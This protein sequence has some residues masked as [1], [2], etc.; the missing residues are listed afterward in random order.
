MRQSCLSPQS[1][2]ADEV[3]AECNQGEGYR[4]LQKYMKTSVSDETSACHARPRAYCCTLQREAEQLSWHLKR[5][6][7]GYSASHCGSA[8]FL[9]DDRCCLGSLTTD[10]WHLHQ[11]LVR[12]HRLGLCQPVSTQVQ[13]H[14]MLHGL[15][16]CSC[17][18]QDR[19]FTCKS[20]L[21]VMTLEMHQEQL[22]LPGLHSINCIL[23]RGSW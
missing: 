14:L 16:V 9:Q 12:V 19:H 21:L 1:S 13:L 2:R 7:R 8:G 18:V 17:F 4:M 6:V 5:I 23:T 22:P 20:G 11:L 10:F 15:E 3:H